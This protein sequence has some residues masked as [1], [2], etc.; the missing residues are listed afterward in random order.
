PAITASESSRCLAHSGSERKPGWNHGAPTVTGTVGAFYLE[1]QAACNEQQRRTKR[2][3]FPCCL[4]HVACCFAGGR[5]ERPGP[6]S[7]QRH[8]RAVVPDAPLIGARD[9]GGGARSLS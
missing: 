3:A 6:G 4:L 7:H 2:G 1:Q 8:G 5:D 9:G